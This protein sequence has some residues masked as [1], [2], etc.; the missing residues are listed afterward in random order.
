M[1]A[2]AVSIRPTSVEG[3]G[4]EARP[5]SRGLCAQSRRGVVVVI[6]WEPARKSNA[7]EGTEA[8]K[9]ANAH[10]G[11]P[12]NRPHIIERQDRTSVTEHL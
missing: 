2:L 10:R 11:L 7:S 6:F 12:G 1:A 4:E 9:E 3:L 5:R 8:D